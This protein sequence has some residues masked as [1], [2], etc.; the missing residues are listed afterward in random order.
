MKY[1]VF[2]INSDNVSDYWD[3]IADGI[4]YNNLEKNEIDK[5]VELSLKQ[6]YSI[7]IQK[8]IEEEE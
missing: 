8:E 6:N 3:N 7:I 4:R 1:S 2:I 5:L